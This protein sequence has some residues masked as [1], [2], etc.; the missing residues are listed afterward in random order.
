MT[1]IKTLFIATT[2]IAAVFLSGCFTRKEEITIDEN[3]NTTITTSFEGEEDQYPPV[4]AL[5]LK[6]P[7]EITKREIKK[8]ENGKTEIMIT[9]RMSIPYGKKL[10]DR[11][12]FNDKTDLG[13]RFPSDVK[14]TRKGSRTFYEFTRRYR[15]RKYLPYHYFYENLIDKKIEEKVLDVGI[16]NVSEKDRKLYLDQL[17]RAFLLSEIRVF[18]DVLGFMVFE[19]DI[20][21]SAREE[22]YKAA[23]EQM[24]SSFTPD[25]F[26]RILAGNEIDREYAKIK[27]EL[28]RIFTTLVENHTPSNKAA[29][30]KRF[31]QLL[32]SERRT[33]QITEAVNGHDFEVSIKMPGQIVVTNGLLEGTDFGKVIWPFKGSDL[34][35]C[36][37]VLH[38][39]SVVDNP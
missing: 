11:Y 26:K 24:H 34:D 30:V 19:N 7:W 29:V 8:D 17:T 13:L 21:P 35:D 9:S 3:G 16:F 10:P 32:E 25:G 28:D 12:D 5:P 33:N 15:P 31:S 2:C 39:I 22:L 1:H 23:S 20:E 18:Y 37:H 4:Y 36:E 6:D 27:T 38:A 14:I